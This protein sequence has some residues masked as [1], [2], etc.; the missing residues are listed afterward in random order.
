[1]TV[2][3]SF[4]VTF[5]DTSEEYWPGVLQGISQSHDWIEIAH[6]GHEHQRS[7]ALSFSVLCQAA[8][9]VRVSFTGDVDADHLVTVASAGFLHCEVALFPFAINKYPGGDPLRLSCSASPFPH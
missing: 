3:K 5:L 7:Q 1:M 9:D 6:F 2:P 8:H 4:F